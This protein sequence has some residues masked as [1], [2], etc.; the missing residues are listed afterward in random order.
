VLFSSLLIFLFSRFRLRSV[1]VHVRWFYLQ[2]LPVV[3][4]SNSYHTLSRAH[5]YSNHERTGNYVA[6]I[7]MATLRSQW[8]VQVVFCR[9]LWLGMIVG[10]GSTNRDNCMAFIP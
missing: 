9:W 8:S 1:H 6:C 7:A 5:S 3:V 4:R 10:H 2:R